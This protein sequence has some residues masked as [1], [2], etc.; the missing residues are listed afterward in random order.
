MVLPQGLPQLHKYLEKNSIHVISAR[1]MHGRKP[2]LLPLLFWLFNGLGQAQNI[3][4]SITGT[5]MDADKNIV[6]GADITIRNVLRGLNWYLVSGLKGHFIRPGLESGSYQ[7]LVQFPGFSTYQSKILPI[8]VGEVLNLNI[9]LNIA[10]IETMIDVS[11][12]TLQLQD[13]KQSSGFNRKEMSDLPVMVSDS[14][15]NFYAQARTAPGVTTSTLAHRPFAINGQRPRNNNYVVDSIEMND[16]ASGFIAGRG[17][18]EQLVSQE[19]IQSF[20]IITHN[21]KA[22]YGRNSGGTI[23]IVTKSGTNNFHGSAYLFHNNSALSARNTLEIDKSPFLSNL[24]GFTLGGPILKKK[25]YFFGNLEFFRPRGTTLA[26]FRTL[27][28]EQKNQAASSV[29]PLVAL[30]PDPHGHSTA[31]ACGVPQSVN[32]LTYLLRTDVEVTEGQQ[33]AIRSSYTRGITKSTAIGNTLSSDV[34]IENKTRG[35]TLHYSYTAGPNW[36]NELRLGYMRLIQQDNNFHDPILLGD[37]EINGQVGFMIVP[38]L[39]MAGPLSFLGRNQVQNNYQIS[40]DFSWLQ[41][42]HTFKLG[43]SLRRIQVNGGTINNAFVGSLFFPNINAFLAGNPLSYSRVMGNPL[44]GLRRWEW[45]GYLQDDWKLAQKLFLNLGVR[46]ELNTVPKEVKSRIAQEF[47]FQEDRNNLAPRIGFA[48]SPFSGTVLRGGYGIFY[49]AVEMAFLGLSRF[50]PPL[51]QTYSVFQPAFPNLLDRAKKA[52]PSGLVIPD[53]DTTTPYAQHLNLTLERELWNPNVNFSVA[54]IGTIGHHLTRTR[55]PNGGENLEQGLRPDTSVGVVNRLESSA[56]SNYHSLQATFR[57]QIRGSTNLRLAYT[58]SRFLDDVSEIPTTNTR[59][60]PEVIPLDENNLRLEWDPSKF[61]IPH[62]LTFSTLFKLPFLESRRWLGGWNISGITTFQ[63]GHSYTIYSGTDSAAGNTNNRI[64]DLK[65]SLLKKP[66]GAVP[67]QLTSEFS[68]T[69]LIPAHGSLGTLGRNTEKGD[70]LLDWNI[71][72]SKDFF[73]TEALRV[74]FRTEIFN[75]FNVTNFD[76]VDNVLTS[77]T[78]GRHLSAFAPRRVQL[79]LR[80]FF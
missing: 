68:A 53:P 14:G 26:S 10:G 13:N 30:Y 16:A 33:L 22:E 65:G 46:Y 19:S 69:D 70:S 41:N 36:F 73:S 62:I 67:L 29:Q 39:S 60:S 79:A 64:N 1:L 2:W 74:Q 77:P 66:S 76:E 34:N 57:Y 23:N 72:M 12:K 49:N 59:L 24:T 80:I 31:F 48:W 56:S 58:Y 35:V 43:T 8:G 51:L 6:P 20:E 11:S 45:H 3:K 15:R 61:N 9:Q 4:G 25:L 52:L 78:F 54:Y 47:L 37:P 42:Q 21:S 32:G 40:D 7:V 28:A 55:R 75:L 17:F 5:V 27:T 18:T 50:N 63:S 38:G 44:I 71:A